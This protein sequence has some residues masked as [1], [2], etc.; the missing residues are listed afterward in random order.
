V[1]LGALLQQHCKDGR[2]SKNR[3][4]KSNENF[5]IV[6]G[7]LVVAVPVRGRAMLKRLSRKM[8]DPFCRGTGKEAA[9]DRSP[10]K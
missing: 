8:F 2:S 9:C 4:M 5:A 10:H 7:A 3:A 6:I 1:L